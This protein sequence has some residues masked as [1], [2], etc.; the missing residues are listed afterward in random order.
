M[1]FFDEIADIFND[2]ADRDNLR[3]SC[4][5]LGGNKIHIE[6]ITKIA[7][8]DETSIT[9]M[10]KK[11]HSNISGEEIK[12]VRC[13]KDNLSIGGKIKNISFE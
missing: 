2:V 4:L 11:G 1:P 5:V 13:E 7:G 10:L 3:V 9:V 12:I 8:I 6:G